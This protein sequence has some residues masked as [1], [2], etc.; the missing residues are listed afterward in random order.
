MTLRAVVVDD[1]PFA[2]SR[3]R[4]LLEEYPGLEVVAE[5]GSGA[6]AVEAVD[7]EQPDLVFLD[8]EMPDFDG[9]EVIRRL[10]HRP[11][12][13]FT[14]GH[15]QYAMQAFQAAG[16]DYL[17]KPIETAHLTRAIERVEKLR[18]TAGGDDG[19]EKR[20]EA[21]LR[22]WKIQP[23]TRNYLERIAVRLGERI[24]LIDVKDVTHFY[25]KD[26]YVF[27]STLQGK[28][29]ILS[30]TI[31]ELEEQLDPQLFVRVHRATIV[32]VKHIKEIQIWFGGKYRLVLADKDA[33]EVVV[34]KNMAKKLKTVLPF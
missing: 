29:H 16:V 4:K 1:D 12:V 6:E 21:L 25:A 24:L 15:D 32:N 8:I 3:L 9:F 22:T 27:L 17:L 11:A 13:I 34:S 10:E 28:E 7:E 14:T 2:R 30:Q 5:G 18:G 19:F 23:N 31:Q 26:K 20:V 33:T